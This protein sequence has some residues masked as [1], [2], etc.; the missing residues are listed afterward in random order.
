MVAN[1][2][3]ATGLEPIQSTPPVPGSHKDPFPGNNEME[4]VETVTGT[5]TAAVAMSIAAVEAGTVIVTGTET[6]NIAATI[7]NVGVVV[8]IE[9]K[10]VVGETAT[11]IETKGITESDEG[12]GKTM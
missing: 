9:K 5:I 1:K 11:A 2:W 6:E 7:T 12:R 4:L 10:T 3:Y 8:K